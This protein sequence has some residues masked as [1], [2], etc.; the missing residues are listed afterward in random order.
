M[1]RKDLRAIMTRLKN[2]GLMLI[3]LCASSQVHAQFNPILPPTTLPV[4]NIGT[5]NLV[6]P[7]T[8]NSYYGGAS[9]AAT[10]LGLPTAPEIVELARAL[11]NDPDLIYE[12]VHNNVEDVW[13]Y[14]EHKGPLGTV[15]DK[16]GTQFDQAALMVA[17]LRQAGY[18]ASFQ[19]GTVTLSPGDFTD[20]TGISDAT[21]ACQMLSSGG[22]PAQV[23]GSTIANCGYGN[24]TAISS[25]TLAHVWVKVSIPGSSCASGC[26]F[27]PSFKRHTWKAGIDLNAA[28]GFTAGAALTQAT[29][30]MDSGNLNSTVPYVHKLNAA[31]LDGTLATYASNLVTWLTS[32]QLAAHMDDIVGGGVI[33]PYAKSGGLIR[34][35]T[36]PYQSMS[37]TQGPWS[38]IPDV[39]RGRDLRPCDDRGYRLQ[40]ADYH[41]PGRLLAEHH[42][43]EDRRCRG[44]GT[45]LRGALYQPPADDQSANYLAR[46]AG[47][48][49]P[50]GRSSLRRRGAGTGQR[51]LH[52]PVAHQ[53]GGPDHAGHDRP[54][55]GRYRRGPA[56]QMVGG[57]RLRHG[58]AHAA[59]PASF[60][61]GR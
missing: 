36:L 42:H 9:K 49:E 39:Y 14:A 44:A 52:G 48:A 33:V 56:R 19:S 22:F 24:G 37:T 29:A 51:H 43:I 1:S 16:A 32:N 26:L 55:L 59:A 3:A 31:G 13:M 2:A 40:R 61:S 8:A 20:W 21:A 38:S 60:M 54:C 17:L 5:A 7:T 58:D 35:S 23:N 18:T 45:G 15:I 27:D 28:S 25:V 10:S 50:Q 47:D 30:A 46:R 12:Y 11:K 57:A 4:V 34:Q 53:G 41:Q 6:D